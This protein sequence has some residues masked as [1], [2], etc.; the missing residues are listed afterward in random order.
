MEKILIVDDSPTTRAILRVCIPED[1]EYQL[2]EAEDYQSALRIAREEKP[3][4]CIMDYNLEGKD[5]ISIAEMITEAGVSPKFVLLTGDMQDAIL[6]RAKSVGFVEC[7]EK[8][9]SPEQIREM[10]KRLE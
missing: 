6:K 4:I 5:G 7:I 2:F 3:D 9:I 8:P 1:K 10:L